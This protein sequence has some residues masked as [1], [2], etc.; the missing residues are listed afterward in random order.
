MPRSIIFLTA[1]LSLFAFSCGLK[2][3]P[4]PEDDPFYAPADGYEK[5]KNGDV[6][7]SREVILADFGL[8]PEF[9]E[10]H[11][12][13]YRTQSINGTAITSIT[14]LMKPPFIAKNDRL[15]NFQAAEDSVPLQCAPSYILR[16]GANQNGS[17]IEK[18]NFIIQTYLA[19]GYIVNAPDYEGPN[20]AFTAGR[21]SG[22]G[23]LDSIRA[24]KNYGDKIDL[25]Q[26][27]SIIAIGYSG[28]AIAT[29]WAASLQASYAPD[30]NENMKAWAAGGTPANLTSV[31]EKI[32]GTES[33]GF[34]F[35]SIDGLS[36]ASS[37][38]KSLRPVL[39][40]IVTPFGV[41]ALHYAKTHCISDV[42]TQYANETLQSYKYFTIQNPF[43]HDPTIASVVKK[44]TIGIRPNLRPKQPVLLVHAKHDEIIPYQDGVELAK[45]WCMQGSQVRFVTLEHGDHAE[46]EVYS[47]KIM[48][49]FVDDI[50]NGKNSSKGCP[51]EYD[52]N[53]SLLKSLF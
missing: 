30:L 37:Y 1:I 28:G 48:H 14:T 47:I 43:L 8:I 44:Q 35:S 15:I 11:Q 41:E 19:K 52:N 2:I 23:V 24:V 9:V 18:E 29:A 38:G 25:L 53:D 22:T 40:Q 17:F 4:N 10:A 3:I 36:T 26:N 42:L 33:V 50:F 20:G 27:S 6:S 45:R 13:Q 7:K 21:S 12:L 34:F 49:Q 46:G 39:H 31:A 32:D 51:N 16:L 5:A